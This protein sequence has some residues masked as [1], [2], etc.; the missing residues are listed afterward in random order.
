[1]KS[2]DT[3][4]DETRIKIIESA[5]SVDFLEI[6]ATRNPFKVMLNIYDIIPNNIDN[7]NDLQIDF[8]NLAY[9][10]KYKAPEIWG[11]TIWT[12]FSEI[13]Y[14]Y[15]LT[16]SKEEWAIKIGKIMRNE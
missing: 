15:L 14:K 16:Y 11:N 12:P 6:K 10:G 3:I 5:D 13:L 1:M 4:I 9:N 2:H 7:Y 8:K